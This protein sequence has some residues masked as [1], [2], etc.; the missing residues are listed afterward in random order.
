MTCRRLTMTTRAALLAAAAVA[1]TVPVVPGG[2]HAH[3]S[4]WAW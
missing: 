3:G 1:L 2:C 4:G